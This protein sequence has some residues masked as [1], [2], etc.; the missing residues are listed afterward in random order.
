MLSIAFGN[1][2]S[3]NL[4]LIVSNV[5]LES[6][7]TPTAYKHFA[8]FDI[9]PSSIAFLHILWFASFCPVALGSE[10]L[11]KRTEVLYVILSS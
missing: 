5:D 6:S 8:A 3:G 11:K 4:E 10:Q 1:T 9:R 2:A 7:A